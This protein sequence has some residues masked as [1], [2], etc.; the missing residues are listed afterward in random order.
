MRYLFFLFCLC[1]I[2]AIAQDGMRVLQKMHVRYRNAPCKAYTFSQKNT[3][4][5]NDSVIRHS[6][7]HEAVMF[8]DKFKI[9]FDSTR[10]NYVVFRNDSVFN[11]AKGKLKKS[12]RDSSTLLLLLGG[13]Y[14]RDF[15]DVQ[16]RL[17]KAG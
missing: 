8:P 12:S 9:A 16:T 3:H 5:R 13:M 2:G 14:Y 7:W 1:S 17:A 10:Q 15:S 11:Y 6:V 4:Y